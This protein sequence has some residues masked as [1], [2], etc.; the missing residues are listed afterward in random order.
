MVDGRL[1]RAERIG[2]NVQGASTPSSRNYRPL[3]GESIPANDV[4]L[5]RYFLHVD[6]SPNDSADGLHFTRAWTELYSRTAFR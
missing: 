5:D 1:G 2:G 4:N 6:M 3:A